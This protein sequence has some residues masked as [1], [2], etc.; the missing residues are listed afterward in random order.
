MRQARGLCWP[1]IAL[2][3]SIALLMWFSW[4]IDNTVHWDEKG[5]Y[6]AYS[7]ETLRPMHLLALAGGPELAASALAIVAMRVAS[8][9]QALDST[10]TTP[11]L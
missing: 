9:G 3:V 10:G 5:L 2:P 1:A 8:R 4:A 11:P 6:L 7:P